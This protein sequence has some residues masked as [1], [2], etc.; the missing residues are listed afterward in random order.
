MRA[1]T[2]V[3]ALLLLVSSALAASA[4]T[5]TGSI[6]GKVTDEQG[7]AVPGATVTL[8]GK[9]GSKTTTTVSDGTY[10][11]VGVDPGLYEVKSEM[12][13]FGSVKRDDVEVDIAKTAQVDFTL[14]V[15]TMEE[16]LTVTGEAPVVDV[17]SSST[18]NYL[19]QDLLFNMP[20]RY[21]NV[22]TALL[23]NLP[24]V[25]NQSAY[26][27]DASSANAL[28]IDG[29]DTRDPSGGTAWTFYNFNIV[30]EVQAVGLGAPAEFGSF[31]G[32]A[33]NTITKSGGNR[34]AGLFDVIYTK[35]SL[36]SQNIDS[37]IT[38]QNPAL[39]DPSK[40][41]KLL[42][43]T[44]QVSGP[45]IKDKLFFFASAQRYH[46]TQDPSGPRTI[47][48]EV[49]PR[50]NG[51]LTWQPSANDTL[52]GQ[53]QYDS[54]SVIGRNG[55]D[56]AIATDDLT[57]RE[58]APEWVWLTNWRHLFGSST[59][60]EVKYTGWWGFFDLTPQV[61][62]PAHFDATSSLYSVS[63][64]WFYAAD[65][66][67]HQVNASVSHFADG[68]GKHDLKFGV[69]I[70]RSRTRD[71]YGYTNNT[72]YYDSAGA[73]YYAYGYGYD[74]SGRNHR[75]SVFAQDSWRVTPRLTLNVG[76]RMD[77][78]TGGAPGAQAVYKNTVFAPRLGFALDLTGDHRT[79]LKGTYG[80]YYEG[81]FN[82]IYKFAT[83]GFQDRISWDMS[84]CPEYGA[85]G[86]DTSY[87]CPLEDRSEVNRLSQPLATI[88]PDIKH[89]RV[90]E[91]SFGIERAVGHSVKVAATAVYRENKN[92]IGN[93]LPDARWELKT[94]TSTA[95]PPVPGCDDCSPLPSLTTPAYTWTNREASRDN[96]LIT[97][98][99]GFQFRDAD[100]NVLGTLDSKRTYQA[101]MFMVSK[102]YSN[103]W[104]GQ[105]SYVYSKSEGTI[106]NTSEALFNPFARFS[107]TPTLG[108]INADGRLTNDRPH[109]I[110]AYLGFD[111]PKVDISVNAAY[112]ML[113]GRTYTPFQRFG[114][115]SINFSVTGYYFGSSAGRQPLLE[116]RGSRRLPTENVVDL[117][118][119]KVFK[120]GGRNDRLAVYA[121]FLNLANSGTVIGRLSRVPTTSLSLP[122]PAEPGSAADV[123]FEAP[124]LVRDPRQ[125]ILGARWSF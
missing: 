55:V 95:S 65:R 115:S 86:P 33:I 35:A 75:E 4:Q 107:Q 40:T 23:N 15:K 103:R 90:D 111:I 45:I 53:V 109:E 3:F 73:P 20:I 117:R 10:R 83:P 85:N 25:N 63:Q 39:G 28:L 16:T 100:G 97:N 116:P 38:A 110:K 19:S 84:S 77:H 2:A 96:L 47:R 118:L 57:N 114:S 22:A 42:D 64:G 5:F 14:K 51:K 59:F 21:G 71:R 121:D 66:G 26:G 69:E 54:Y 78:M 108:L 24:G 50:F 49:S 31:T 88:D 79:V 72:Y 36:G 12:A 34:Y 124:S 30:E 18:E 32:A 62:A 56:A 91:F 43:F 112:R 48:D 29:V 67:R 123:P 81:I 93:V 11:F 104:R 87:Q 113:S 17:T 1:L 99:D 58:D 102:N 92:F 13:S 106:D 41:T 68:W 37:T 6:T 94:L 105:I 74:L 9:T 46:L 119:E 82:D 98:S 122:P 70:E 120:V 60:T 125:A 44:T 101:L 52:T 80:Q 76:G 61:V 27:A 89:P 8:T 7:A